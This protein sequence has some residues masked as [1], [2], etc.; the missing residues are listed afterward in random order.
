MN[1][2]NGVPTAPP[3]QALP[4]WLNGVAMQVDEIGSRTSAWVLGVSGT[5]LLS[6]TNVG[7]AALTK[8]PVKAF[9]TPPPTS[10]R[11]DT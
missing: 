10:S 2:K 7:L 9:S 3:W 1:R 5:L 11:H 8:W 6:S 4:S